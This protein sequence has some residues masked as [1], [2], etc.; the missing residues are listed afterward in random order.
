MPSKTPPRAKTGAM[1]SRPRKSPTARTSDVVTNQAELN[2]K[3]PQ[4]EPPGS[5]LHEFFQE[6][7]R[8]V[9][10]ASPLHQVAQEAARAEGWT[11]LWEHE[12]QTPKRKKAGR[13]SGHA[14][15][16]RAEARRSVLQVARWRLNPEHR[17]APFKEKSLGALCNEYRNLLGKGGGENC[18]TMAKGS[19]DLCLLVPL[20]LAELSQTDRQALRKAS[21]E[22]LRKDLQKL[23]R[24]SNRL[25]QRSG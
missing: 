8:G 17:Y 16:G 14:R 12:D 15:R 20:M 11:A 22:T 4:P 23:L 13:A 5:A 7:F 6:L 9:I 24:Q 25:R 21:R 2:R 10:P 1:K 3:S 19:N 18:S